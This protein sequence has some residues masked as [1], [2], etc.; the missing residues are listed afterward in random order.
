MF[1]TFTLLFAAGVGCRLALS[2]VLRTQFQI[3]LCVPQTLAILV[4]LLACLPSWLQPIPFPLP[5]SLTL[6][7]LL[8]DLILGRA[9]L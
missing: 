7:A 8:S 4:L 6:G 1:T 5:F 9:A 3:T 2:W